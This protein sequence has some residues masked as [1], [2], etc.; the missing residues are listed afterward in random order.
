[1][2]SSGSCARV[3]GIAFGSYFILYSTFIPISLIVSMEFVKVFQGYFMSSD[4]EMFCA[5]N[6]R[7][8]E[9]HTVSINEELGQVEYILTD[10]TG[11]LTCNQMEFRNIVIGSE[12]YGEGLNSAP[13]GEN[14]NFERLSSR[15]SRVAE[16]SKDHFDSKTLSYDLAIEDKEKGD[17]H[18]KRQLIELIFMMIATC[19]ECVPAAKGY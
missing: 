2:G 3:A 12:I 8:L 1:M 16:D 11:T 7:A 15:F 9:C 17:K 4:R 5:L 18:R 6:Q 10:K 19:H 14:I 13:I